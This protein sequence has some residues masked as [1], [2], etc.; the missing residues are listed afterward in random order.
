[1][2]IIFSIRRGRGT[3]LHGA[4]TGHLLC[5]LLNIGRGTTSAILSTFAPSVSCNGCLDQPLGGA[6]ENQ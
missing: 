4:V 2:A 3:P 5:L 1:M 6:H